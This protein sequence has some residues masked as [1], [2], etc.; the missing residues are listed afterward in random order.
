VKKIILSLGIFF[1]PILVLAIYIAETLEPVT[2]P[3]M[4]SAAHIAWKAQVDWPIYKSEG[5]AGPHPRRMDLSESDFAVDARYR[6][7]VGDEW[8][9]TIVLMTRRETHDGCGYK[10]MCESLPFLRWF[11]AKGSLQ[12][13]TELSPRNYLP[14][15]EAF[16]YVSLDDPNERYLDLI[17]GHL[18]IHDADGLNRTACWINDRMEGRL[19]PC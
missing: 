13:E 6:D 4:N 2:L 10:Y 19:P 1:I 17:W 18:E 9:M 15:L 3:T 14:D 12:F 7:Q 8:N 16:E 5:I 11:D